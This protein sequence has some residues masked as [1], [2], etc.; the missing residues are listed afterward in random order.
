MN[1]NFIWLQTLSDPNQ[2]VAGVRPV[3]VVSMIT[4]LHYT[5]TLLY[6]LHLIFYLRRYHLR[7][8]L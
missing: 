2:F 3:T 6:Y 8:V 5:I 7:I 1:I 4:L